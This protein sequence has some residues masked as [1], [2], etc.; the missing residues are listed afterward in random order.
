MRPPAIADEEFSIDQLM[1]DY[2]IEAQEPIQFVRIGPLAGKEPDPDGRIHEYHQSLSSNV[3]DVWVHRA[4]EAPIPEAPEDADTPRGVE[5]LPNP[6]G[7]S[8]YP[9]SQNTPPSLR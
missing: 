4:R 6:N 9:W 1:P 5:A 8:R 7:W 2:F 3:R